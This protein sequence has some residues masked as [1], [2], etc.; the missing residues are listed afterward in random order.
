MT[1]SVPSIPN[2]T[3]IIGPNI[4]P[5]RLVPNCWAKK[6]NDRIPITIYITVDCSICLNCG[7]F[8]NPSTAEVIEIGGVIIPSASSAAPPIIAAITSHFFLRRTRANNAK[9]PPSPRLSALNTNVTYFIVVS[10]VSV[11]IMSERVPTISASEITL[12]LMIELKTYN[13]D[14]PISP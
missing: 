3:V 11:Q 13:G 4:L 12:S 7:N 10:K 2:Q 14:V 6:N 1:P 9:I 5:I 8:F